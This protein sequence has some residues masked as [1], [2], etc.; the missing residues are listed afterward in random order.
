MAANVQLLER[1]AKGEVDAPLKEASKGE[2]NL[3]KIL[4]PVDFSECS[5]KALQY[6]IRFA[7]AFRAEVLLLH[8]LEPY[9]PY[10]EMTALDTAILQAKSREYGEKGLRKLLQS[11]GDEAVCRSLLRLGAAHREIVEAAKEHDVDLIIISTHGHSGLGR[12]MLG[13]TTERVVR[14]AS[15]PVFVVQETERDFIRPDSS[16]SALQEERP[17]T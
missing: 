1:A 3:R 13:S 5:Q 17:A 6:A 12:A 10:P 14:R 11:I 16:I 2:I 8:V 9:L 15:C 7:R 4:V